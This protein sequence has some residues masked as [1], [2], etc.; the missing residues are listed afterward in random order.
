[1]RVQ[2]RRCF[3]WRLRQEV[4]SVVGAVFGVGRFVLSRVEVSGGVVEDGS[5]EVLVFVGLCADEGSSSDNS[6]CEACEFGI[7]VVSNF[8]SSS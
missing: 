3:V 5:V 2:C 7:G 4:C 6:W 8:M 1:M